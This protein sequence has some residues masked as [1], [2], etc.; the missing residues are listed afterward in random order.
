[1][2]YRTPDRAPRAGEMRPVA[3]RAGVYLSSEFV[4]RRLAPYPYG[5]RLYLLTSRVMSSRTWCTG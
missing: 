5:Y 1:M 3:L 4:R 2:G